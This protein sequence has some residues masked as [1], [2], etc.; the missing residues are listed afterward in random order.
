MT[1]NYVAV[2]AAGVFHGA[3]AEATGVD[4]LH[5]I[6]PI[7]LIDPDAHRRVLVFVREQRTGV[8]FQGLDEIFG[9][10]VARAAVGVFRVASS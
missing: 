9:D 8:V 10:D 3:V 1:E 4:K 6:F 2:I 7:G 5:L